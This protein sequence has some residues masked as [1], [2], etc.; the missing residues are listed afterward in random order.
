MN[1]KKDFILRKKRIY[2]IQ[3]RKGYILFREEKEEVREFVE[4]QLRKVY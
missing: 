4:K 3:R 2:T 1:L